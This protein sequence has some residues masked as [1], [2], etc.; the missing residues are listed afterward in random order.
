MSKQLK[1]YGSSQSFDADALAF[2]TAAG[3]TDTTQKSA[4]NTA[5]VS[6]KAASL[7]TIMDAIYPLVGGTATTHKFNLKNPLDTDG[8]FRLSFSGGWAHNAN[9]ITGNGSNSYADTFINPSSGGINYVRDNARISFYCRTNQT[10][11]Y[12]DFGGGTNGGAF[13]EVINMAKATPQ[14]YQNMNNNETANTNTLTDINKYNVMS[15]TSSTEFKYYR[16]G[17][18]T[19]TFTKASVALFNSKINL[20]CMNY[21]GS[22]FFYSARNYAWF[23]IGA[24]LS[25]AQVTDMTNIVNAFQATLT[26]NV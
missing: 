6:L 12:S 10:G 22:R 19:D 1:Y 18:L 23:D 13:P 15:R 16:N 3:I 9:G 26:R 7:W 5:V 14:K 21:N 4:I 8:A 11:N 2:I 24:G 20:G 17:T 25:A